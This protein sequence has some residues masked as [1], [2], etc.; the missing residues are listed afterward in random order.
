[1]N[2]TALI[3][4]SCWANIIITA[5]FNGA[6]RDGLVSISLSGVLGTSFMASY[7]ARISSIS[8]CTSSVPRSQVRAAKSVNNLLASQT[9]FYIMMPV[10]KFLTSLSLDFLA[11]VQ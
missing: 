1:M 11:L 5:M 8:S 9:E 3:P 2:F 6:R 10:D 7:S 4:E